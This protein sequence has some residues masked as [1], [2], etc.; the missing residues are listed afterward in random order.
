MDE[1]RARII[2]HPAELQLQR[3]LPNLPRPNARDKE[4]DGLAFHMQ[5]VP[6]GT[7]TSFHKEGIVLR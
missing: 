7:T 4:V 2:A 5:T 6:G 3:R 1:M